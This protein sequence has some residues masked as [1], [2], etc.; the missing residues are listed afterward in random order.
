M[1]VLHSKDLNLVCGNSHAKIESNEKCCE[2]KIRFGH[3]LNGSRKEKQ[4]KI[5]R[6]SRLLESK[7]IGSFRG[8]QEK[9]AGGE[10]PGFKK[11]LSL[12]I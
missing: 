4:T 2:R 10:D 1:Q 6:R 12:I 7:F 3:S 8:Y 11:R 9:V 5:Q